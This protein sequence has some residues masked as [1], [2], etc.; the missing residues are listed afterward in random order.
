MKK[1]QL[2]LHYLGTMKGSIKEIKKYAPIY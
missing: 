2:I 1:K